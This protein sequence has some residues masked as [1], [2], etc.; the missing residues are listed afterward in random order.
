M[1]GLNYFS[2]RCFSN[3][4]YMWSSR[5]KISRKPN[6]LKQQLS[7]KSGIPAR[8]DFFDDKDP[9]R[10]FIG[11]RHSAVITGDGSLY[12]FG[13]GAWGVLGHGS[14]AGLNPTA[15]Q[16]VEYF[17][18]RGIKIKEC[19]WGEYHTVALTEDGQVYS[20]GYG[21]KVGY[22]SWMFAQE[23]G[24]LGHGDKKP[25]FIPKKVA[26]FD[27]VES[28]VKEIAAGLYH[29]IALL[30]NGDVYVWG[31]GQYGVLGNGSNSYSLIPSLNEEF[32]NMKEEGLT[33]TKIDAAEESTAVLTNTGEVFVFGK[34]DRGQ[35]GIGSG[36]GIDM[37]ESCSSPSPLIF[38]DGQ[39]V[40][41]SDLSIG[42]NTM[43]L[44]DI[45]GGIWKTG[46]KLDYNP[47]KLKLN[48]SKGFDVDIS[49]LACGRK[50]Y[51]LANKSN[52]LLVWGNVFSGKS[53]VDIDGFN[54]YFGNTL[55][56]KEKWI[57]LSAKYGIFGAITEQSIV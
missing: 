11:P 40:R 27:T 46:L 20:W 43:I 21:G 25:Y 35:L 44:K 24:A 38:E 48:S 2:K 39:D 34:N 55:F 28:K 17:A 32:A 5:S 7:V 6:D 54:M 9:K 8:V 14:E 53:E 19:K 29:T 3:R 57:G 45:E 23:V 33:V 41:F 42:Q 22:F 13:A 1:Y 4:V 15:P 10:L 31:R 56:E 50:H 30:E 47:R 36:I 26:F 52:Q 12:T 49:T 37:Q 51:L 18:E 16:K